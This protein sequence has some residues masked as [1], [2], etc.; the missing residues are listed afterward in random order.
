MV[1]QELLCDILSGSSDIGTEI[2]KSLTHPDK[3]L[4]ALTNSTLLQSF[5]DELHCD[6]KDLSNI[7][8]QLLKYMNIEHYIQTNIFFLE[9]ICTVLSQKG[10]LETLNMYI[11]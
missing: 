8:P 6:M 9:K 10:E 4:L 5:Q 3:V 11:H 7:T 1:V 2:A